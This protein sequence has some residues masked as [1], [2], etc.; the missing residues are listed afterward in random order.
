MKIAIIGCGYVGKAVAKKWYEQGHEL[1]VTTTTPE[2][3]PQLADFVHHVKVL[4][5]NDLEAL[6]EI[7]QGQDIILLS[8]GSKG[9]TEEKYRFSYVQTA[10]NLK[11]ALENNSTV[12]QVIYTSSYSIVGN[13]N[14]EWVDETTPDKPANIFAEILLEVEQILI[15]MQTENRRVCILRLGGIYG[16]NREIRKIFRNA[17]GQTRPGAGLEYGNWVHLEDIVAGIQFARV[18]NLSGLFN[19]VGDEPMQRKV[20]LDKLAEKYNLEPVIWDESQPSPRV[21]NVRVSNQKIK[22]RGFTF[23]YPVIQL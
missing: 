7:C 15:S 11:K 17:M 12:K 9:R 10:E 4:Q 21:F 5:G 20:M 3:V 19:L 6:K 13:H 23:K 1:T 8:V 2:K 22:S 14:G 18:Q 16:E